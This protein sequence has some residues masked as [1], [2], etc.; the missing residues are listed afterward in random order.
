MYGNLI[1]ICLDFDRMATSFAIL[2]SLK[3]AAS[4]SADSYVDE[5][6]AQVSDLGDTL[7]DEEVSLHVD[8]PSSISFIPNRHLSLLATFMSPLR[9]YRKRRPIR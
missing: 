2:A 8:N 3:K 1:L 4:T 6:T 7:L 5:T 9:T